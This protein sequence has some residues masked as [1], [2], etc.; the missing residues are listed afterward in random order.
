MLKGSVIVADRFYNDFSLFN[1]WDSKQVHF[2][3]RYKDNLKFSTGKELDL[4]QNRH[5]NILK[6]KIIVL[7]NEKSKRVYTS[8]LMFK[9][10]K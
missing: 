8:K 7:T 10:P 9:P 1:I 5:Q 6:D 3:I 2:V 4:P